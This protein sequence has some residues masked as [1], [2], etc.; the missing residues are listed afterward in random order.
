MNELRQS[1]AA[2]QTVLMTVFLMKIER[3]DLS[4]GTRGSREDGSPIIGLSIGLVGRQSDRLCSW[5]VWARF[6]RI[7]ESIV[8]KSNG[9]DGG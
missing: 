2:R 9:C 7:L 4:G 3:L 1:A 5:E 6:R 8:R